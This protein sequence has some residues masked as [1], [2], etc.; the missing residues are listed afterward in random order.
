[1][2]CAKCQT[3]LVADSAFCH[4]CGTR[5]EAEPTSQ[6][7]SR[8]PTTSAEAELRTFAG[9]TAGVVKVAF[10]PDGRRG[11]SASSNG[12]IYIW[13]IETGQSLKRIVGKGDIS[14]VAF[15]SDGRQALFYQG[16]LRLLDL[17]GDR[18]ASRFEASIWVDAVAFRPNSRAA[19]YGR[20]DKTIR[21]LDTESGRELARLD[22]HQGQVE[23]IAC[24]PD[25]RHAISGRFD[26]DDADDT[27]LV[28]DL[29]APS[30]PRR[31]KCKMSMASSAAF[32][33]DGQRVATGTFDCSVYLWDMRSGKEIRRY[34]GHSGNVHSV[35]FTPNGRCIVS[36]SG[37]DA[38]D[39]GMLRDL[40][41][42]N[43]VRVWDAESTR[44]ICRFTGHAGNVNCVAISPDGRHA[45]SGSSDKT[46]RLWALPAAAAEPIVL[47]VAALEKN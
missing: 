30:K 45:L 18:Q 12:D 2:K 43:T 40:G 34:E 26:A 15:S 38:Y 23:Y 14:A 9:H 17:E 28:W 41:V 21:L 42:D 24:S 25:G 47:R 44:E 46:V 5:V 16:E 3:T 1:M 7:V 13:D 36:A 20:S 10:S 32:S 6:S 22:G 27:V 19:L 33:A 29:Q 35:A 37:T 4:R 11:L 8:R 31:P 39:A